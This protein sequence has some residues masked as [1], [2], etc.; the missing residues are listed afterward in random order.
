MPRKPVKILIFGKFNMSKIEQKE[1]C[2]ANWISFQFFT[3]NYRSR[4]QI[5]FTWILY[6]EIFLG[7]AF[8][9][10][11]KLLWDFV[12]IFSNSIISF[13]K[14]VMSCRLVAFDI[15]IDPCDQGRKNL[16]LKTE[17]FTLTQKI[18]NHW[19]RYTIFP[20]LLP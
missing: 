17:N 19:N 10:E 15:F 6:N 12:F 20:S 1:N 11:R 8:E 9:L 14:L 4:F 2:K 16:R 7:K 5:F 13:F 3:P 18:V